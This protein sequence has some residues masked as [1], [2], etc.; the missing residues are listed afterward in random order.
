LPTLS[1]RFAV[2]YLISCPPPRQPQKHLEL[3]LFSLDIKT[4][5]QALTLVALQNST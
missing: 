4:A 1:S 2:I 5:R 3:D